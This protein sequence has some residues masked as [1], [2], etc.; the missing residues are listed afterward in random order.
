MTYI[1]AVV[2]GEEYPVSVL[3]WFFD[4][5]DPENYLQPFI[6]NGGIGT[7]VTSKEGDNSP[8]VDPAL[9][10]LL[11]A[12][13]TETDPAARAAILV[14]GAFRVRCVVPGLRR[15]PAGSGPGRSRCARD[16]LR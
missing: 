3:G 4:F 2:G 13:R 10:E 8:G 5:P 1:G 7:M 11:S 16:Q 15:R 9:L 14:P 6:E 12:S